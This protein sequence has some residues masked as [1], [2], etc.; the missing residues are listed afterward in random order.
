MQ[1]LT[2]AEM[3]AADRG[4]AGERVV[5]LG[6]KGNN[7]GDGLVAAR[8]LAAAGVDVEVLLL[9]RGDEVKGEADHPSEQA[10]RGPRAV[11]L[12]R[13][14][15]DAPEVEVREVADEAGL[16]AAGGGVGGG[17]RGVDWAG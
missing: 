15:E 5:A 8:V 3:S 11:A 16:A 6:G 9:G 17:G 1:I 4:T 2:S 12:R 14:R 7:G 13:L 10:R